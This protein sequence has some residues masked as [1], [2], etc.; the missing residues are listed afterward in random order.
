MLVAGDH[1]PIG[2]PH[3]QGRDRLSPVGVNEETREAG[4][5][6]RSVKALRQDPGKR[7]DADII[8]DMAFQLGSRQAEVGIFG[9]DAVARMVDEDDKT[10]RPWSPSTISY[11]SDRANSPVSTGSGLV[12]THLEKR[13]GSGNRCL[14]KGT[15]RSEP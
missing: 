13:T 1:G 15:A 6:G 4:A 12:I 2:E 7:V 3:D 14:E 11:E 5:Q 8:G 9:R 10:A